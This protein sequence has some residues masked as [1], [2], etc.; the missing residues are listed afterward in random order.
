MFDLETQRSAEEVGGWGNKHL[1]RLSV[2]VVQD[3]GTKEVY[4]FTEAG[5]DRLLETL[6]GADLVVG[7]N[8]LD[9]DYQVLRA[10]SPVDPAA[11]AVSTS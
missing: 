3:L 9:F 1:M 11:G 10:Y 8:I 2:A 5:V 6:A 4:T 7:F